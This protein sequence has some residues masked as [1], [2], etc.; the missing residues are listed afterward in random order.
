MYDLGSLVEVAALVDSDADFLAAKA[1]ELGVAQVYT[2][3]SDALAN[4][5]IDA[6]SICTPH[7]S[8]TEN[9]ALCARVHRVQNSSL[10]MLRIPIRPKT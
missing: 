1:E 10:P 3:Y 8:S 7:M 2:S 9:G 4:P 5:A 6:V